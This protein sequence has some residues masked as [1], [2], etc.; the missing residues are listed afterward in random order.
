[1]VEKRRRF[2]PTLRESLEYLESIHPEGQR[3]LAKSLKVSSRTLRH[4]K[5]GSRRPTRQHT[6]QTFLRE[7]EKVYPI[8]Q[9]HLARSL[10]VSDRTIRSW[11]TGETIPS[12]EH[13]LRITHSRKRADNY[14]TLMERQFNISRRQA[15][16]KCRQEYKRRDKEDPDAPESDKW[17]KYEKV[18][19]TPAEE[20]EEEEEEEE[21]KVKKKRKRKKR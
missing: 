6:S 13:S 2:K 11:K 15:I 21:V 4:W 7:L 3:G 1:M 9:K 19:I 12:L 14:L 17:I 20:E 16:V 18:T 5:I 10:G 8:G